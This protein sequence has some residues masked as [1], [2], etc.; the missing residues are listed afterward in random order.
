MLF[1]SEYTVRQAFF[2]VVS[3]MTTTGFIIEDYDYWPEF[4]KFIIILLMFIGA[5]GGSTGGGCKVSR[6][7]IIWRYVKTEIIR[8]LHPRSVITP[9]INSKPIQPSTMAS[10]AAFFVLYM[11]ILS[12]STLITT[13]YGIDVLT[14]FTGILTCLSNVGPGVGRLGAVESFSWLPGGVK[15]VMIID[16]M[17]GRL[18]LFAAVLL[19]IPSTY[20]K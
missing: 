20:R 18:E 8:Q 10:C 17:A 12:A 2:H 11:V 7:I 4:T 1:R 19:I 9:R 16:M 5:S 15:W 14:A 13:A 6:F 3:V